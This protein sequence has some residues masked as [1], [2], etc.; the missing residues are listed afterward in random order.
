MRI[1]LVTSFLFPSSPITLIVAL[2]ENP[3]D[4]REELIFKSWL[5]V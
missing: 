2:N 1:V 5:I 3:A 4:V